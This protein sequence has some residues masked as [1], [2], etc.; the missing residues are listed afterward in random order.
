MLPLMTRLP[1][2][3]GLLIALFGSAAISHAA[4]DTPTGI[5]FTSIKQGEQEFKYAIYVPRNYKATEKYPL[6]M[7]LHGAGECGT[8]GAKQ[9][10]V[11]IGPAIL[12][13]EEKWNF[14]VVFAQKPVRA[15]PWEKY[16]DAV[17]AML[18]KTMVDYSVDPTRLYLTGLSQG[19]HGTWVIGGN[20]ADL[21]AAIA[22]ICGYGN[23]AAIAAPLKKMPIWTFH[24]EADMTVPM[25]Q[26]KNIVEAVTAAGGTAKLT[27]YP[28]VGHDS[29]TKAYRE[30]KL[31]DWFLS[32][33]KATP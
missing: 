24:G 16:D 27:T 25:S 29:W 10:A 15:D 28:G 30:E 17:M 20:H 6:I 14:I 31:Y 3:I 8:D 26:S 12:L 13:N 18:R 4:L 5:L 19:G 23:A 9:V 7:F 2:L 11:G 1:L 32:H 22:P 21:W 33:R